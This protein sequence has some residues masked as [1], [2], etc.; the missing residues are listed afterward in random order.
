MGG[1]LYQ[2]GFWKKWMHKLQLP[3]NLY[4]ADCFLSFSLFLK[5]VIGFSYTSSSFW[6]YWPCQFIIQWNE[7]MCIAFCL[8]CQHQ[9]SGFSTG[10]NS[11]Q[12]F[13]TKTGPLQGWREKSFYLSSWAS[14]VCGH[15]YTE[16]SQCIAFL[17]LL[18]LHR[19]QEPSNLS[20]KWKNERQS[21]LLLIF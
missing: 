21:T 11:Q 13:L 12:V 19:N 18:L 4:R 14:F 2:I 3:G 9:I 15:L 20:Q 1:R 7:H 8:C 5:H 10:C 17:S 16:C 6:L